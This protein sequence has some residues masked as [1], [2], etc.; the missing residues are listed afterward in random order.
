MRMVK[1][2]D[3]VVAQAPPTVRALM[4]L[5]SLAMTTFAF[6]LVVGSWG[7]RNDVDVLARAVASL[8][9]QIV[10][11]DGIHSADIST[12][13]SEQSAVRALIEQTDLRRM[14]DR[15]ARMDRELCLMRADA[16]GSI[17]PQMQ[18]ECASR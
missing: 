1:N 9:D 6:G 11:G 7:I 14:S 18:Q 2:I 4:A 3:D 15:V 17:T 5:G 13:R 10:Q 12:V 8:R 16:A